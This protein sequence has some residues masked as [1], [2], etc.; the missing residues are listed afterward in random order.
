[1]SA[2]TGESP[3]FDPQA[4]TPA[5]C[6]GEAC[7]GCHKKWPR[8]RARVGR[9]PDGYPVLACEDCAPALLRA[10]ARPSAGRP[11]ALAAHN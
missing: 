4:L 8:P 5:Q 9:L 7:V 3:T 11:A 1:M 10:A 6:D 2:E